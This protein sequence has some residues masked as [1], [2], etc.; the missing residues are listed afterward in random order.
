MNQVQ[1]NQRVRALKLKLVT[2]M[3]G[4]ANVAESI[5]EDQSV[6]VSLKTACQAGDEETMIRFLKKAAVQ[7]CMSDYW[8]TFRHAVCILEA[9]DDMR[10]AANMNAFLR[11]LSYGERHALA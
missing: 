6:S 4:L 11:G 2:M 8:S 3:L 5:C 7:F 9:F 10:H 1:L